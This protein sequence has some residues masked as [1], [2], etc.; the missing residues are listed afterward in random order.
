MTSFTVVVDSVREVTVPLVKF[1]VTGTA[2]DGKENPSRQM[3][4]RIDLI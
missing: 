3:P 2:R 1:G 4:A